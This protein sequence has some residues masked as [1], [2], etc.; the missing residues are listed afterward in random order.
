MKEESHTNFSWYS[1]TTL[2]SLS[3]QEGRQLQ[4]YLLLAHG[5][6]FLPSGLTRISFS[7]QRNPSKSQSLYLGFSSGMAENMEQLHSCI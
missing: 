1:K 7:K 3:V 5:S 2:K 6:K 4:L